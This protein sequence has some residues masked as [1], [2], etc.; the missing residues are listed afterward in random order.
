MGMSDERKAELKNICQLLFDAHLETERLFLRLFEESDFEA[1]YA[2]RGDESV[3]RMA[4]YSLLSRRED[5]RKVFDAVLGE[6]DFLFHTFAVVRKADGQVLGSFVPGY[7]PFLERDESLRRLRGLSLSFS[8]APAY[9]RQ[10][11]MTELLSRLLQWFFREQRFDFVNC[12]YFETN[13]ASAALQRKLGFQYY[14]RHLI[15]WEDRELPVMEQL[16]TRERYD[17]L[18][19]RGESA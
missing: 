3:C 16:L 14:M 15:S 8:L 19:P 5:V 11:Y 9:Q 1:F 6:Y 12:G 18:H 17:S 10:G 13:Q 2:F 4:G 7:Y